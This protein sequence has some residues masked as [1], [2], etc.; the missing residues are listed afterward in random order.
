MTIDDLNNAEGEMVAACKK[1]FIHNY[2]HTECLIDLLNDFIDEISDWK[3]KD[4]FLFIFSLQK[5]LVLALFSTA[6]LHQSQYAWNVRQAIEGGIQASY[7]FVH[8]IEEPE[9]LI[10]EDFEV[11]NNKFRLSCYKWLE[12]EYPNFNSIIKNLKET[13]NKMGTHLGF[14]EAQ[15][16]L[17][18]TTYTGKEFATL[19]FDSSNDEP[20]K[21]DLWTIANIACGFLDFFLVLN[22]KHKIFTIKDDTQIRLT[23]LIKENEE[24][25]KK[26]LSSN[27]YKNLLK[28]KI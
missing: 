25:K 21:L 5:H 28:R 22:S 9:N 11:T 12:K 14:L 2:S 17:D 26:V 4:A 13:I 24:I 7:C 1:Y 3:G 27:Y 6:R 15:R 8:M 23:K 18:I 16:S 20:I 19:F 10:K